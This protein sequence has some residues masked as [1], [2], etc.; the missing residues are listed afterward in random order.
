MN[1]SIPVL[2]LLLPKLSINDIDSLK[3]ASKEA[4]TNIKESKILNEIVID[5]KQNDKYSYYRIDLKFEDAKFNYDSDDEDYRLLRVHTSYDWVE[6]FFDLFKE[7]H[8]QPV[9]IKTEYLPEEI[10]TAYLSRKT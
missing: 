10:I 5:K 8:Y 3:V 4:Y 9:T 1:F 2:E 7:N 6:E